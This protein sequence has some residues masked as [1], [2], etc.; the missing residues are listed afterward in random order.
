MLNFWDYSAWGALNVFAIL[1]IITEPFW[2]VGVWALAL[3]ALSFYRH[4]ANIQ[5]LMNGTEN[6]LNLK[7]KA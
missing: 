3:A 1:L 6:K 2:P 5:R 7:K 4:R